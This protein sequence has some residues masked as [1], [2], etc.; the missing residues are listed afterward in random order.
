MDVF[1]FIKSVTP[2]DLANIPSST[3]PERCGI[4]DEGDG[5]LTLN[6]GGYNG[7]YHYDLDLAKIQKPEDLLWTIHH[8]SKKTWENMTPAKIGAL[9]MIVARIKGWPPYA[10]IR[11]S[12]EAPKPR[13]KADERA[14]MTPEI[15]YRVI[16][17]DGYRCRACGASV[18]TG[19]ILHV[20]HIEPVS[21]GGRTAMD[22][23]QTLCAAC[24]IGKG[25]SA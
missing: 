1:Q 9:V 3:D 6:W 25:A 5:Y 19:A 17:R 12:H 2:E 20:D 21:A 16:R 15:R 8:L 23:R 7:G 18:A 14:K 24:N 11:N 10:H 4:L 22:N 13:F